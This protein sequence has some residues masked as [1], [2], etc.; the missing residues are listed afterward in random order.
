MPKLETYLFFNGNCAEA[1]Q[2]YEKTLGGKANLMKV[3][4][5]P[6]ESQMPPGSGNKILHGRLDADGGV[7]MASD[8]L[9][10]QPYPGTAGFAV[11]AEYTSADDA[12]RVF[13][14]LSKGGKVTMPLDKTFWVET[15]GM[16]L[17]RFGVQWMISGG[18][19]AGM[20]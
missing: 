6:A 3:K 5:S 11:A 17:D 20:P 19:A 2:F 15:F 8:W 16:V 10:P 13:K 18:K 12:K 9:A 1:M 7:L 4:G 14:A